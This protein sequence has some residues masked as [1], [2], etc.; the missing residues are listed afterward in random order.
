MRSLDVVSDMMIYAIFIFVTHMLIIHVAIVL[1]TYIFG[2][3]RIVLV[4]YLYYFYVI[5]CEK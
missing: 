2:D 3:M 5:M 4:S 1:D